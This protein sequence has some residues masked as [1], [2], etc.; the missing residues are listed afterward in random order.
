[1]SH[2]LRFVARS[3]NSNSIRT[4]ITCCA[5]SHG[6]VH[7][8]VKPDN[9]LIASDGR[10]TC[11][12]PCTYPHS[13]SRDF[14]SCS[15]EVGL[16]HVIQML[17]WKG[18]YKLGDFGMARLIGGDTKLVEEGDQRYLS[19]EMLQVTS[20]LTSFCLCPSGCLRISFSY[21]GSIVVSCLPTFSLSFLL[22]PFH[23]APASFFS[24]VE[25]PSNSNP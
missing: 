7:L 16:I 12:L 1:M 24:L 8:D 5:C 9:F 6:I 15:G 22:S 21:I 3:S 4:A 2:C 17:F 14:I 11:I 10:N 20:L 23:E 13:H 19:N 18:S 25:W